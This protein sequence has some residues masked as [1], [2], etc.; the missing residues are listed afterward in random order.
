MSASVAVPT[1]VSTS[2]LVR[3]APDSREAY[4]LFTTT[5]LAPGTGRKV[6]CPERTWISDVNRRL[7]VALAEPVLLTPSPST[8]PP[9]QRVQKILQE[10]PRRYL[11]R[12]RIPLSRA[13]AEPH[14]GRG[15]VLPTSA[16]KGGFR[17]GFPCLPSMDSISAVSSPQM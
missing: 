1:L 6:H 3:T 2:L 5:T 17:R 11:V 4:F 15:R 12:A 13:K 8:C 7:W 14:S 10:L 16:G 9:L